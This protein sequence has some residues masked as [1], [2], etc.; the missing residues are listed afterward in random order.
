MLCMRTY[1]CVYRELQWQLKVNINEY[2]LFLCFLPLILKR[3]KKINGPRLRYILRQQF[4]CCAHCQRKF[5][6]N[7][8][9]SNKT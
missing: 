5:E 2:T 3:I 7:N 6:K 4:S 1:A 8:S 9:N